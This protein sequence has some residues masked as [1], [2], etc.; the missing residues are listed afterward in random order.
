MGYET[1][2]QVQSDKNRFVQQALK[3]RKKI[4]TSGDC[5]KELPTE[6]P[7]ESEMIYF[8]TIRSW[9]SYDR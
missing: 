3:Y 7:E 8:K 5:K 6:K 9:R 4:Q 2:K 1:L